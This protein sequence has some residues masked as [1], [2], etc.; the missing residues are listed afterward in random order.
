MKIHAVQTGTVAIRPNQRQGKGI[1][2]ARLVNTLFDRRWT[3]PLPIYA[4]VIEHPEGIIVIDT[5][6]SGNVTSPG[7]FPSWNPY[8]H[9][10]IFQVQPEQEIG[11]QLPAIGIHPNE[12]RWVILTHLHTDHAGGLHHFPKSEILVVRRAFAIASGLAAPALGFLPH[13]WPSWFTPRLI[14]LVPQPLGVFPNSFRVTKNGDVVIVATSGHTDSHISVILQDSDGSYFFAGDASYSEQ[15][16]VD[17]KIDG[18]ALNGQEAKKTLERIREFAQST[19]CVY[20]PTH[21]PESGHRLAAK[22]IVKFE[23]KNAG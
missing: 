18:L 23:S 21:D 10:V 11:P 7:Y 14:N 5:G 6:E 22:K 20:L 4:W 9:N 1:G 2:L 13:H 12:V 16:M 17:Q 3:E 19:P 8:L 15:M